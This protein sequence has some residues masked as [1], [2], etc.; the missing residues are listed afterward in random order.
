MYG[1]GGQRLKQVAQR[2]CGICSG[3]VKNT[4]RIGPLQLAL[5][6]PAVSRWLD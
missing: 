2:V 1:D 3:G 5:V 4:P 6:A